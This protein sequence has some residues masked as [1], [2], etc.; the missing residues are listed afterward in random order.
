MLRHRLYIP[1]RDCEKKNG[2]CF[3]RVGSAGPSWLSLMLLRKILGAFQI[4]HRFPPLGWADG[5]ELES[6]CGPWGLEVR[7]RVKAGM[8]GSLRL[9]KMAYKRSSAA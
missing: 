2:G 6:I 1:A 9:W 4:P 7:F 3:A 8:N 5:L